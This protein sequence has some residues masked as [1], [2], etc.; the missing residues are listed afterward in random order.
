[1]DNSYP[2]QWQDILDLLTS[3][4]NKNKFGHLL[5]KHNCDELVKYCLEDTSVT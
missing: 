2:D 3:H 4:C 1:M 5:S